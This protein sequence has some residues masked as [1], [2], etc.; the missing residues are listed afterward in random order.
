MTPIS[1]RRASPPH[2]ESGARPRGSATVESALCLRA[3]ATDAPV[4]QGT[5][6]RQRPKFQC[7]SFALQTLDQ[8]EVRDSERGVA[9]RGQRASDESPASRAAVR[10][11][12]AKG[13]RHPTRVSGSFV[14]K[15]PWL[16][17]WTRSPA[18]STTFRT[19]GD[20]MWAVG[21]K[22]HDGVARQVWVWW[23]GL[24]ELQWTSG[25]VPRFGLLPVTTTIISQRPRARRCTVAPR[26][27][28]CL[29]FKRDSATGG[30]QKW[31]EVIIQGG[32]V[33]G[34]LDTIASNGATTTRTRLVRL[35]ARA[36]GNGA[37]SR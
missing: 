22:R 15:Q 12:C 16:P 8:R 29:P 3:P 10:L 37:R 23:R 7:E 17:T 5:T 18:T 11:G 6:R 36:V 34:V 9:R 31:S 26:A 19:F 32:V 27:V 2:S 25:T 24:A 14:C 28:R 4:L 33:L 13:V 30:N 1:S 35:V 20:K 21:V